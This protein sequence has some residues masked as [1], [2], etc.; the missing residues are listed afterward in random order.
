[1]ADVTRI[2]DAIQQG[3]PKAAGELLAV[4]EALA[5]LALEDPQA[6][7]VDQMR[8]FVGM[9]VPEIA[10]ALDL[11]PRTVDRHWAFARSW[12]KRTI[13]TSLSGPAS[14]A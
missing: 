4:N 14:P 2:F 12:L 7:A 10:A 3:D 5:S 11:A 6:A 9:T 8:Y 13:R 1:M